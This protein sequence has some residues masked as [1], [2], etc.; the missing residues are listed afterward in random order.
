[1]C[2]FRLLTFKGDK[3]SSKI[4]HGESK[5][6]Q[7]MENYFSLYYIE[8]VKINRVIYMMKIYSNNIINKKATILCFN[9]IIIRII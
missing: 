7:L 4:C 1:M 6:P 9:I 8:L 2:A 5:S 3:F